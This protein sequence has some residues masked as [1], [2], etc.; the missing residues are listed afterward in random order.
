MSR[1]AVRAAF[2]AL[3]LVFPIVSAAQACV[4]SAGKD[5]LTQWRDGAAAVSVPLSPSEA[6]AMAMNGQDCGLWM[7]GQ[8]Q[9]RRYDAAGAVAQQIA[10]E[11]IDKRAGLF[12]HLA[13]D[14]YDGS[15]WLA[16][17]HLLAHVSSTGTALAQPAFK[18]VVRAA[19]IALDQSVW[20]LTDR[21]I[22]RFSAV[23]N[24][25]PSYELPQAVPSDQNRMVVDSVRR[26]AWV[27]TNRE[28]LR[29]KLESGGAVPVSIRAFEAASGIALDPLSGH[30]W[31][32]E[33]G[34]L[35]VYDADGLAVRSI[36]LAGMGLGKAE[37]IAFDPVGKWLWLW[38]KDGVVRLSADGAL[39]AFTPATF[40][41]G[42]LATPGF[43]LQPRID[44]VEPPHDAITNNAHRVISIGYGAECN[45]QPCSVT[46]SYLASYSLTA[47]LNG[48]NV[49]SQFVFDPAAKQASY[50]PSARLPEGRNT[51]EAQAKD[52]NDRLS[53]AILAQFTVDTVPPVVTI[54]HPA[55]GLVTN[56]PALAVTGSVN[57]PASVL[58]NNQATSVSSTG[59]FTLTMTLQE[60]ANT[61]NAVAVDRAGNSGTAQLAVTL[62]TVPPP[63]PVV[64]S[65]TASIWG[66]GRVIVTGAAGSVEGGARVTV[67]SAGGLSASTVAGANGSF[68]LELSASGGQALTLTAT[69]SAGNQSAPT[70]INLPGGLPPDPATVAT[71]VDP[72][73]PTQLWSSTAFLYAGS[74]PIQMGVAP[75]TIDGKRVAVLRGKVISRDGQVLPG[76]KITVHDHPEFGHTFS[77]EDGWFDMAV[78][79][80]G[81]LTVNYD[82][83]GLLP[84][85]RTVDTPWSDFVHVPDAALV[86]LDTKV[87]TVNLGTDGFQ[88]AEGTAVADDHG[89]RQ[90]RI[91]FPPGTV[92]NLAMPDGTTRPISTLSVRATEYTVGPNGLKAMPAPL[93][94]T[95]DYTYAV[96]LSSDEAIAAGATSV[97]FNQ[98]VPIYVDNFL[99]FPAGTDVPVGYYDRTKAA[100][101]GSDNGRVITILSIENGMAV[102]DVNGHGEAASAAHLAKLGVTEGELAQL[103]SLYSSGHSLWRVRLSHFTPYDFNWLMQR[104]RLPSGC[105]AEGDCVG[106]EKQLDPKPCERGGCIIEAQNQVLGER[107]QVAG[108]PFSLEYRSSRAPG[109]RATS[110]LRVPLSGAALP[111]GV[112][113]IRMEIVVAGQRVEKTFEPSTNLTYVFKWDGKDAYGRTVAG[114]HRA[115]VR[116]GYTHRTPMLITSEA[117]GDIAEAARRWGT[118]GEFVGP[119]GRNEITA[120]ASFPT[121]VDAPLPGGAADL[122]GWSLNSRHVYDAKHGVLM[123]GDGSVR[124]AS[125]LTVDAY[126]QP[127]IESWLTLPDLAV[128]PVGNVL[129]AGSWH[130]LRKI[131]PEGPVSTI[132]SFAAKRITLRGSEMYVTAT[133]GL[134]GL[135]A[136]YRI[137]ADLTTT[138]IAG[139]P[140]LAQPSDPPGSA[141]RTWIYPRSIAADKE[142]N[143]YFS[144]QV[145]RSGNQTVNN[146]RIRRVNLAGDISDIAGNGSCGQARWDEE[147]GDGGRATLAALDRPSAIVLDDHGNLY[148]ADSFTVRKVTPGGTISTVAGTVVQGDATDGRPATQVWL[149]YRNPSAPP[150][151]IGIQGIAIDASGELLISTYD[152]LLRLTRDGILRTVLGSGDQACSAV[153][154]AGAAANGLCKKG[155][156]AVTVDKSGRIFIY[157]GTSNRVLRKIDPARAPEVSGEAF[158]P[159]TDGSALYVFDASGRHRRT[160]DA[161]LKSMLYEFGYDGTG[162]LVVAR[163]GDG[164]EMR[165]E[166]DS[167]GMATALVGPYGHRS[168]LSI[169]NSGRLRTITN[170]AGETHA[171][172]YTAD[173]LLTRFT[174]PS[175]SSNTF[176][177]D[178]L[179]LLTTD[180]DAA[181]GGWQISRTPGG[182]EE[183]RLS[184]A[185]GRT[186][187]Y[188]SVGSPKHRE[189]TYPDGSEYK[190]SEFESGDELQIHADGTRILTDR[191]QDPRFGMQTPIDRH[192]AIRLPSGLESVQTATRSVVTAA[193]LLNLSTQTDVVSLNGRSYAT[194][195]DAALRQ[196]THTTPLNRRSLVEVDSQQRPVRVQLGTLEPVNRAYN[197]RGQLVSVV[198]GHAESAREETYAY[199]AQGLLE[200][201]TH[202]DGRVTTYDYDAGGRVFR[203][204][205]PD[206]RAISFAYDLNGNVTSIVPPGRPAHGIGYNAVDLETSYSPPAA[207]VPNPG[208]QYA[209]DRDKLLTAITRPDGQGLQLGYD[210]GGR[211]TTVTAPHGQTIYSYTSGRGTLAGITAPGGVGLAYTWDGF[212]PASESWNGPVAGTIGRTYNND[213]DVKALIV[214][215]KTFTFN[216]DADRLLTGAGSQAIVRDAANGYITGTQLG[217]I[218]TAQSYNEF[219]ELQQYSA[220]YGGSGMLA[221][222]YTYDKLGRIVG[223]LETVQGQTDSY[224]Y[225]YDA[226]GRLITVSKNGA[227]ITTYTYDANGNRTSDGV[228][229]ASYDEQDRLLQ[230]GGASYTYTDN[231]ELKTKKVG[232]E[233]TRYDYDVLGNLRSA[234]LPDGK[235][236]EYV[237]DGRNRRIGK[238]VNGALTQ[239][240]LYQDQLNPVA[241]LDGASNVKSRF[242]YG[243]KGNVPDYMEKGGKTY[244]IVS[245]HLGSVRMVVDTAT[246]EVVQR[247]DYDAFGWVIQD[248][249]PG[250]QPY[251]FAGGIYDH[252]TKL[253]RFG[254]R[255]YDA[256]TG[257]WTAKDP[258]L[259]EGGDSNLFAYVENDPVA[260][261]DPD[262][263]NKR[264]TGNPRAAFT[265]SS[266]QSGG[267]SYGRFYPNI[268]P[269]SSQVSGPYSTVTQGSQV[270][271]NSRGRMSTGSGNA[272]D[273]FARYA[274]GPITIHQL[275][276]GGIRMETTSPN[277]IRIQ[278]REGRDGPRIDIWPPGG[279]PETMHFPPGGG[280]LRP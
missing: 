233:E 20:L 250:F 113:A 35:H 74:N 173:G 137:N 25:L 148:I 143:I 183:V 9:L 98:P 246:G 85:Q 215:G 116:I 178:E 115:S 220:S 201:I 57:E 136:I 33:A 40:G 256:L 197:A 174:K 67:T 245:D 206:G 171:M 112:T 172:A 222:T 165:V 158:V 147:R 43:S 73:V 211:L 91:L 131:T 106:Q 216:Y 32:A 146:C 48:E 117:L 17:N 241:E 72:A 207:G 273:L 213:F 87:T 270:T 196:Y 4:W 79:G 142:G 16:G 275:P 55:N 263:H 179:G 121:L 255:D 128:D 244:R 268:G 261:I 191:A 209:Y 90:V 221:Q 278:Y 52:I 277:G 195:F 96:E 119:L 104:E 176:T 167:R 236:I 162:N 265:S 100:W 82:K 34:F 58:V 13:V 130:G 159:S 226:A 37:S 214:A 105:D 184:S 78:N 126:T 177:Y 260:S 108:T 124:V 125:T 30:L 259:F 180:V 97:L 92:A 149:G 26:I 168:T 144:Q 181:G 156:G 228:N 6:R 203:K 102:L 49:G 88:V 5:V 50:T 101:I 120:W 276:G 10:L 59:S 225:G 24:P 212:L 157:E 1:R 154:E 190:V 248:T 242:I 151:F 63:A 254:A 257:R 200:R 198:Q 153:D 227:V 76:V 163:D 186:T 182:T 239:G 230:Y 31:L 65:I 56:Q 134:G 194:V 271:F 89:T 138:V 42:L 8:T 266:G 235:A 247:I 253:T 193:G 166:R 240:L 53:N 187:A 14:P 64:G 51:L 36:N 223:K 251:G 208:T 29:V 93:P 41:A 2:A 229:Q 47:V 54:T 133:A 185:E 269:S 77:R 61:I 23:G 238:K 217:G 199:N 46:P 192:T 81:A 129:V 71:P 188:R 169:D 110:A 39:Q 189:V 80:G 103:A 28:L 139:F 70:S 210:P 75:G 224:A 95:T 83:V 118:P 123:Q 140:A 107:L 15:V 86:P 122:G 237:I 141:I 170:P 99:S 258:I 272:L 264:S 109:Y 66:N 219:G 205:L 152:R 7:L 161:K 231:G 60:G 274:N 94:P 279:T 145:S 114:R 218:S 62:D 69:D 164:N 234:T 252:D 18:G 12:A 45:G 160:L 150:Q 38:T 202:A 155:L 132:T 68:S 267:Y 19:A 22:A 44:L 204:V 249:N 232:S 262:G 175:G 127:G 243:T 3:A 111:E 11:T 135:D 84:A 280:C 27:S 21:Q